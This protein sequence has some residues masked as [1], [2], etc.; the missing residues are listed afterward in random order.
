MGDTDIALAGTVK[1]SATSDRARTGRR[2][3]GVKENGN[4][5]V[6]ASVARRQE[7]LPRIAG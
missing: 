1:D 7:G 2:P 6:Y 3:E 4:F 5:M